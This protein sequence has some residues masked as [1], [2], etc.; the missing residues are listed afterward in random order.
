VLLRHHRC[1]QSDG[2]VRS[3]T[4][5]T[6]IDQGVCFK[7][8]IDPTSGYLRADAR[9]TRVGVFVYVLADGTK[10]RELRPPDEVFRPESME[11]LRMVPV[12]NDHPTE[13]VSAANAR[14]YARGTVSDRVEPDGNFIA[15]SVAIWDSELIV[16]AQNG[17]EELSCGY[18]CDVVFEPGMFDGIEYDAVQRNIRYNH[19]A[20]VQQGR[21]GP[22]VRMRLDEKDI[23]LSPG[24]CAHHED[25]HMD[26]E[27][28]NAM[29]TAMGLEP[30]ASRNDAVSIDGKRYKVSSKEEIAALK[31]A[32]NAYLAKA[33][34]GLK[35]PAKEEKEKGDEAVALIA[36]KDARIDELEE[37]LEKAAAA[38]EQARKDG[39]DDVVQKRITERADLIAA[40]KRIASDLKTDGL[41]NTAIMR[42]VLVAKAPE[43]KREALGKKLDEGGPVYIKARFDDMRERE[44][45]RVDNAAELG[46]ATLAARGIAGGGQQQR[47]DHN[48]ARA[49]FLEQLAKKE[50]PKTA[51]K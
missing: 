10:R 19:L 7:S 6:R 39:A 32:L 9:L 33:K 11:S 38:L 45:E 4:G 46:A 51:Q 15:A 22:A 18:T 44:N 5:E 47:V 34:E 29:L 27:L 37:K 28:L 43:A 49:A 14:S 12:C 50:E 31:D 30:V 25:D 42:S 2:G 16:L 1:D 48:A 17:K 8:T 24:E 20:V 3:L 23:E 40:A 41:D 35:K 26:L 36:K 13:P 21:A